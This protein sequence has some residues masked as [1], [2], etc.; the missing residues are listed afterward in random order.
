MAYNPEANGKIERGHSL[1][2]KAFA[3]A[4]D[5]RVK[6]WP[7]MLPYA[8]WA[9]RTTHSSVTGYMLVELMTGQALV[10]PTETAIAT[11][12]MLPWKEE[13]SR[14]ELLAVRIRQLEGRS[15]DIAEAIRRQQEAQFRNKS[16]FDTKHRLRPRR[17]EEGDWV[18]VYD[19]SLDHNIQRCGNSRKDG[20]GHTR[21]GKSSTMERTDCPSW[22]VQ[23]YE[24]L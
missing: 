24:C 16:R 15:E 21:F 8:L 18:I 22:M 6:D 3:K 9:D 13:M 7:Q 14:E 20:S 4:C 19:S 17:I 12:T 23:Y 2:V 11:W 5:G 1:I 10:M